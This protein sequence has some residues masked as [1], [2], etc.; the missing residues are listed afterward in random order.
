A[1]RVVS[2]LAADAGDHATVADHH[3]I[4]RSGIARIE[5]GDIP[6]R[7]AAGDRHDIV[8]GGVGSQVAGGTIEHATV[9]NGQPVAP[10]VVTEIE[11]REI[12]PYRVGA[13]ERDSIIARGADWSNEGE[14]H[15]LATVGDDQLVGC[16]PADLEDN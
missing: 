2:H 8:A 12:S 1:R 10:A 5:I 9:G 14:V 13:R 15:N 3:R 16:A 4:A 7:V 11:V 6:N